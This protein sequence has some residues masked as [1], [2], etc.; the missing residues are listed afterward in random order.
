MTMRGWD[1]V[2]PTNECLH[3]HGTGLA[4]GDGRTECGFCSQRKEGQKVASVYD[5]PGQGQRVYEGSEIIDMGEERE[6]H[7]PR[8]GQRINS[9][10]FAR[11]LNKSDDSR[12]WHGGELPWS[13]WPC[14]EDGVL[15]HVYPFWWSAE[16]PT[17]E[18]M[19]EWRP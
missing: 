18:N 3:C 11:L 14:T 10:F 4:P 12:R 13:A 1:D 6:F 15:L 17:A 7:Y 16:M 19:P 2:R 5:N 9:R 8:S